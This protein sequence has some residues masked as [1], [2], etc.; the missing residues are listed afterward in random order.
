MMT[1][2]TMGNSLGELAF[3]GRIMKLCP[4]SFSPGNFP[5]EKLV[6][7][8]N[9]WVLLIRHPPGILQD[10]SNHKPALLYFLFILDLSYFT[11]TL[12][13]LPTTLQKFPNG[14]QYQFY[15]YFVCEN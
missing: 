13:L 4:S 10:P 2:H 6:S 1:L 8:A 7:V 14:L 5:N 9:S 3:F 12:H 15:I 11:I